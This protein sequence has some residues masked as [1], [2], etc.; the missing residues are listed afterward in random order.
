MTDDIAG[1]ALPRTE[2][3]AAAALLAE[4]TMSPL[5]YEHSHRVHLFAALQSELHGLDPDP[6]LL[7]IAALF[8][9]AGLGRPFS[10]REQRF[11]LDGADHAELFLRERGFS[12]RDAHRVWLAIALHTTPGIP[13]R[14]QPEVAAL[15]LGVLT[16]A[17]GAG[18]D[19]LDPARVSAVVAAHPRGDFKHGFLR[20]FHS[21]LASR[22]DTTYGTV[23]ADVLDHFEPGRGRIS[24]VDRVLGSPWPN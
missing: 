18:L 4:T 12:A 11:E 6:E 21:G 17:V 7:Y 13:S 9:D 19:D 15:N 20:E 16:D 10:T 24:M 22:P 23:N 1:I 14:L 8:H 2:A 3:A 5:L